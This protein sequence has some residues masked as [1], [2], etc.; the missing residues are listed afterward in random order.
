MK[1]TFALLAILLLFAAPYAKAQNEQRIK[2]I[3]ITVRIP[4]VGD[5]MFDGTQ[6]TGITT[7][8][9][10]SENMLGEQK[11]N[12]GSV[13]I[14]EF[15][16]QGN[17]TYPLVEEEFQAGREYVFVVYVTNYTDIL[18]NYKNDKNFTVDNSMVNA[19]I[20]GQPAKILRGSSGRPLICE[21]IVKLPGERDPLLANTAVSPA[22]GEHAGYGYVDLGLPSGTLWATCNVGA[23][24][25]EGYGNYYAYGETEPKKTYIKEN[26]TGFGSYI[27]NNIHNFTTFGE[28]N[29]FYSVSTSM[30]FRL[31]PEFDAARRNMG[32]E[33]S[34]PTRLQAKELRENCYPKFLIVNGVKGTLWTSLRNGKS[35]FTPY[36]GTM[37]GAKLEGRGV[38]GYYQTANGTRVRS[39]YTFNWGTSYTRNDDIGVSML[40]ISTYQYNEDPVGDNV[41][42]GLPVRAV[43]GGKEFSGDKPKLGSRLKAPR[44]PKV[45]VA[46]N[47][48]TGNNDSDS[49]NDSGNSNDSNRNSNQKAKEVIEKGI[50]IFN[51]LR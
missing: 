17:R 1:Q 14:Y 39:I 47:D 8:V 6:I 51:F 19:T 36:S 2:Q 48:S 27:Y 38:G 40:Q 44:R 21:T 43:W 23:T 12:G 35:I 50:Q 7:D 26:F 22:D 42:P 33:W 41:V 15:D 20:N 49:N 25:P 24:K 5:A 31:L 28:E 11:I 13:I 16:T 18:F 3:D 45:S 29:N 30:G 46:P 37:V 4:D 34:M 9:F 32:G 10:G